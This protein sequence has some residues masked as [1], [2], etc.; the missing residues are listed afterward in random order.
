MW[1]HLIYLQQTK[2]KLQMTLKM[3]IN[4]Q[5]A[6]FIIRNARALLKQS[7]MRLFIIIKNWYRNI[8]FLYGIKVNG[9]IYVK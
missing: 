9:L 3:N 2:R 8:C 5:G 1:L 4:S 7:A 6:C